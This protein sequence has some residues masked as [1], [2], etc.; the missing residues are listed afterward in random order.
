MPRVLDPLRIAPDQQVADMPQ[1]LR[2]NRL[3]A[4]QR[5]LADAVEARLVRQDLDEDIVPARA[6]QDDID[7]CDLHGFPR[8]A[9]TLCARCTAYPFQVAALPL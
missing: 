4:V 7:P 8:A 9:L 2:H 5:P 1:R 6:G 3:A